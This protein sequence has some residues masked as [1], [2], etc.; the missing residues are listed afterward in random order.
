MLPVHFPPLQEDRLAMPDSPQKVSL[1]E[2]LDQRQNE[3]LDE[4]DKLNED[5][6]NL[7]NECLRLRNEELEAAA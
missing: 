4:L 3:V 6:E 5:V 7:L 2:E 1:L